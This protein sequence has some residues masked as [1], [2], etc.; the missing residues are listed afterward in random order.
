MTSLQKGDL[1]I[2]CHFDT[3]TKILSFHWTG[4]SN[5]RNPSAFLE[6][7]FHE[8]AD[9]ANVQSASIEMHFEKLEHFNSSTVTPILKLVEMLEEQKTPITFFYDPEFIW[10]RA[11]FEALK[12]LEKPDGVLSVV[13][14]QE[15]VS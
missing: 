6:R 2:D 9:R 11:S 5:A 4:R 8:I 10:Q 14:A 12:M 3:E 7:Y 1:F 13:P 15:A